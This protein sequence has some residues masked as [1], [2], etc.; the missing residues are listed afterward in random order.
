MEIKMV[1]G[2]PEIQLPRHLNFEYH[3]VNPYLL[4]KGDLIA[5]SSLDII[6]PFLI[7]TI[8]FRI[9]RYFV[10]YFR[11]DEVYPEPRIIVMSPFQLLYK[12]LKD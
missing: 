7:L 5:L 6:F 8:K 4:K 2:R 9:D 11:T 1:N 12:K 10:T 3:V